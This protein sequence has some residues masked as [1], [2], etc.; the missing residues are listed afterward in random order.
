[1]GLTF[2]LQ[3]VKMCYYKSVSLDT[4][5]L[6]REKKGDFWGTKVRMRRNN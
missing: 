2:M 3:L 4:G 5:K 1:M 6:E